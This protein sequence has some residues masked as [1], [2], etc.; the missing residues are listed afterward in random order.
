MFPQ[1]DTL[2]NSINKVSRFN[3]HQ[4]DYSLLLNVILLIKTNKFMSA[5]P[6]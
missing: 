2:Y 6:H 3:A 4:L 1:L 5:T